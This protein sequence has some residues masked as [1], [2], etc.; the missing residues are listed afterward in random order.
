M[1]V[2]Q[3]IV[4][5]CCGSLLLVVAACRTETQSVQ[6]TTTNTQSSSST[7]QQ[8][9]STQPAAANSNVAANQNAA[10]QN[11]NTTA[12][13]PGQKLDPCSLITA[14]EIAS[15]Q[16]EEVKETKAAP[17]NSSRLAVAQCFYQTITPSKSVS[18]EVTQ[19]LS[20]QPGALSPREFW[21]ESFEHEERE[22][23]RE[24]ERKR[25]G[26]KEKKREAEKREGRAGEEEE[27]N[28]AVR[29]AGVGDDAFWA[30]NV[31]AGAL[32]VLKG[33]SIIRVSIG[34]IPDQNLRLEKSKALA[35]LALKRLKD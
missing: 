11:S 5:C 27:G 8:A 34:G 23:E 13:Q 30:S 6:Q 3:L 1:N 18:L 15:V 9:S 32:Y 20:A 12:R 16:G 35:R 17:G 14:S 25:E 7:T 22:G 24:R 21:K 29:V 33:D 26:E 4:V 10:P 31:R 19:R 28:P 2:K